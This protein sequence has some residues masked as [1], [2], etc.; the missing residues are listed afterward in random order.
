MILPSSLAR[1]VSR[2][3]VFS[4]NLPVAVYGTVTQY[5]RERS[6]SWQFGINIFSSVE[7]PH[8]AS[9]Y[10]EIADFPTIST[11]TLKQSLP[12]DCVPILLRPSATDNDYQVVQEYQPDVHRLRLSA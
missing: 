10:N 7:P 12:I 11:Y 2:T 4:T 9:V 6:F 1:V 3:L 5:P 8:N